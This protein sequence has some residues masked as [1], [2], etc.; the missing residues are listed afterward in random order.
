GTGLEASHACAAAATARG[1]GGALSRAFTRS[2][3]SCERPPCRRRF[4][5]DHALPRA[6]RGPVDF[7][8]FWRMAAS[9]AG[10][11]VGDLR[12]DM[13]D[14]GEPESPAYTLKVLLST[15]ISQ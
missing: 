1:P 4:S 12:R 7:L 2:E 6:V 14:T 10:V 3:A 9:R 15:N 8:E 11:S 13:T 5:R